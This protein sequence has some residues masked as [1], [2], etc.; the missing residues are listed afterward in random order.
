MWCSIFWSL[1]LWWRWPGRA[2][3]FWV[4]TVGNIP[5]AMPLLRH[6]RLC[7]RRVA[8]ALRRQCLDRFC[9][10]HCC[11]RRGRRI[12]PPQE[13]ACRRAGPFPGQ[14]HARARSAGTVEPASSLDRAGDR[15]PR[16]LLAAP[17]PSTFGL[18]P[19][20]RRP[21]FAVSPSHGA[22]QS[23]FDRPGGRVA[24]RRD[25]HR[26]RPLRLGPGV[27][28]RSEPG[29]PGEYLPGGVRQSLRA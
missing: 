20:G 22:P 23:D 5:S 17:F 2:G 16:G 21:R 4:A 28:A 10:R 8:G 3:T 29:R 13:R 11:R 25:G 18:V 9:G 15:R 6:R 24:Q 7:H 14:P 27:C 19:G 26:H 12:Y 1:R